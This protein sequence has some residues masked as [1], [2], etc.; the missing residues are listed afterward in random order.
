[1]FLHLAIK[2]KHKCSFYLAAKGMYDLSL[3]LASRGIHEHNF[4]SI[5]KVIIQR[6]TFFDALSMIGYKK[7]IMLIII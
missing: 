2:G 4:H 6:E 1:M 3:H 5:K 7:Y